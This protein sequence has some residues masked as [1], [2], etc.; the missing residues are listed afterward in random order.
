M[1]GLIRLDDRRRLAARAQELG[2]RPFDAQLLLACAIRHATIA[3]AYPTHPTY[4]YHPVV[5]P[6]APKLS[7][8]YRSWTRA[9][10]RFAILTGTALAVDAVLLWFWL[11]R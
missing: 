5:S 11:V 1:D 10:L 6:A 8:E 7:F 4:A 9:W 2:I 3:K